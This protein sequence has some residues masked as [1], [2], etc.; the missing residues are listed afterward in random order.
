MELPERPKVRHGV[1][2]DQPMRRSMSRPF[3]EIGDRLRLMMEARGVTSGQVA[4]VLHVKPN[5]YSN[6]LTGASEIPKEYVRILSDCYGVS[7]EWV[8]WGS[9]KGLTTDFL[10]ALAF[11]E[12]ENFRVSRRGRVAK[13]PANQQR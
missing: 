9:Q 7:F 12:R 10:N 5:R 13:R 8:Y 3:I 6:W 1:N 4:A 11:V 2:V